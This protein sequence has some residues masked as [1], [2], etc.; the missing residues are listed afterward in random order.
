MISSLV[1]NIPFA[2]RNI[3]MDVTY[4]DIFDEYVKLCVSFST[5][6]V[7][8]ALLLAIIRQESN[9]NNFAFGGIGEIGL[10]QISRYARTDYN[11]NNPEKIS[12]WM[13]WCPDVNIKVASWYL[14]HLV[15]YFDGN[16]SKAIRAYNVGMGTVSKSDTA[17][18]N[19]LNDVLDHKKK[20]SMLLAR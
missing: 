8:P 9:G 15:N 20:F 19:Y 14:Q 5:K 17:G 3:T 12:T 13:L 18:M 1:D 7:S 4:R 11:T 16:L 6:D 2:I 10:C